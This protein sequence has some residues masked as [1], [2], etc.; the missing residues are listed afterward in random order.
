VNLKAAKAQGLEP[1]A[2]KAYKTPPVELP[3]HS[4]A[5][6]LAEKVAKPGV[7]LDVDE[8]LV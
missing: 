2:T 7:S 6:I 3:T 1:S 4:I 5:A 8:S